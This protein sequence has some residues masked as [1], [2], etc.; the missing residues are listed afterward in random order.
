MLSHYVCAECG[1]T[2]KLPG[3]CQCDTCLLQGVRL[4]ECHCEDGEHDMVLKKLPPEEG[5]DPAQQ[6]KEAAKNGYSVNTLD[7]DNEA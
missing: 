1:Y 7:L 5:E 3:T 4:S 2:S 6:E